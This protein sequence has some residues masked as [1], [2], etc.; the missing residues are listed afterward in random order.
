MV[1]FGQLSQPGGWGR[2][3][4]AMAYSMVV[5]FF[6][7]AV[8]LALLT[9]AWVVTGPFEAQSYDN[10]PR[11]GVVFNDSCRGFATGAITRASISGGQAQF[12]VTVDRVVYPSNLT[13]NAAPSLT[14][15]ES[16][17]VEL[18]RGSVVAI[19]LPTGER[20]I[21]G[22]SPDWQKSNLVIP[23]VGLVMTPFLSVFGFLQLRSARSAR[24][25]AGETARR[26][27]ALP[28]PIVDFARSLRTQ[29]AQP[30]GGAEAALLP[31]REPT[32]VVRARHA[33]IFF[34]VGGVVFFVEIAAAVRGGGPPTGRAAGGFYGAV[35]IV[36][37]LAAFIAAM[38][39][40]R[41]L[42]VRNTRIELV[43]GNVRAVDWRRRT[44]EWPASSVRGMLL[45]RPLT[46]SNTHWR[47]LLIL[48]RDG[49]VLVRLNGEFFDEG[50]VERF[51]Q[52]LRIP[53]L[54]DLSEPVALG[55]LN[56]Q[57]PG[58]ATWLELHSGAAGAGLAVGIIAMVLILLRVLQTL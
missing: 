8:F 33:W 51:A 29:P 49:T 32:A 3:S 53:M 20:V 27:A 11:C 57:F 45:V 14:V 26:M 15:G 48:G 2:F 16:V 25:T 30:E 36:P 40:Y 41:R 55:L 7:L 50:D 12:D 35:T 34:V 23:I 5:T 42:F 37:V 10:A 22:S 39:V 47:R 21:T 58:A 9:L 17:G 44:R 52:S 43:Q 56:G 28:S 31:L 38:L 19:T 13:E 1:N 6:V 18:W 24:R 4:R 54:S 46:G